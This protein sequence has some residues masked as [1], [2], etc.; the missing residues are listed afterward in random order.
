MQQVGCK[1]YVHPVPNILVTIW[2]IDHSF[3]IITLTQ[4]SKQKHEH[5]EYEQ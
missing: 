1:S 3:V 5:Y 2:T 4:D